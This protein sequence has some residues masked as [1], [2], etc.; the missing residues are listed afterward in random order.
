MRRASASEPGV[1]APWVRSAGLTLILAAGLVSLAATPARADADSGTGSSGDGRLHLI[2]EV[3]TNSGISAGGSSEFPIKAE[4][5]LPAMTQHAESLE[6][7]RVAILHTTEGMSFDPPLDTSKTHV[8][9]ETRQE[10]FTD[11]APQAIITAD[12]KSS[13]QSNDL[14][15]T[16]M[17]LAAV[18]V[19]ALAVF[20]GWKNATRRRRRHA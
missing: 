11:Y 12:A 5:F 19:A 14:W 18:P 3:I 4:L 13:A 7:S 17:L 15:Y 6:Q 16:V 10:L 20:L 8:Y 2:P 1:T 9:E